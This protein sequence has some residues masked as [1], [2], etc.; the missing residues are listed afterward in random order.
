MGKLLNLSHITS[1]LRPLPRPPPGSSLCSDAEPPRHPPLSA[2]LLLS[3]HTPTP[4]HLASLWALR[5]YCCLSFWALPF[6]LP[7]T[8]LLQGSTW[9][10]P[11][12]V[13]SNVTCQCVPP[14]PLQPYTG[15]FHSSSSIT[16]WHTLDVI[17]D[18]YPPPHYI[19]VQ[20]GCDPMVFTA[21]TPNT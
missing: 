20:K 5:A 1:L 13:C 15:S 17:V 4:G 16:M 18:C 12:S 21:C 9:F 2:P 8:R 10:T 19:R 11:L 3:C 14:S 7:A 6:P